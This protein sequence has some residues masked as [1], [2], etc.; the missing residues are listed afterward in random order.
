[1]RD[2]EQTITVVHVDD[3][4]EAAEAAATR[5]E[6]MDDRFTVRIA[7]SASE[8][9][10]LLTEHTVDCIVSAHELPDETGIDFLKAVRAERPDLPFVLYTGAGSEQVAAAAVSADATAYLRRDDDQFAALA[11]RI[12]E[13]VE[14]RRAARDAERADRRSTRPRER[15]VRDSVLRAQ[16]EAVIDGIL[17][18]DET[19]EIVTYNDRFVEMWD[20]ADEIVEK[21]DH[22]AALERAMDL[23]ADPEQFYEEIQRLYDNP[24]ETSRTEVELTDGRVFER[25]TAP[26][27]G[28]DGTHY[29]RLWTY[30]NITERK[31]RE[32]EL[33]RY[34]RI[35]Q[36][37]DDIAFVLDEDQIVE[38]VNET[39]ERQFDIPTDQVIGQ[40]IEALSLEYVAEHED[41][42]KFQAAID[43]VYDADPDADDSDR[44]ERIELAVEFPDGQYVFEYHLSPMIEDAE[45]TAVVVVMRDVTARRRRERE[46]RETKEQLDTVVRNAPIVLFALDDEGVF[47]LSEGKGLERLGLEPGEVVGMSVFD[48]YADQP[49][50][51]EAVETAL[52]GERTR[53][54]QTVD[55]LYFDTVYQPIIE[56]DGT[57]SGVIGVAMDITEQREYEQQLERQNQQLDE[58]AS[59]VSHDLR[60]PLNVAAGRLDL[61]REECDSD[62]LEHVERAHERMERLIDDLLTLAR[63]GEP[64]TEFVTV[65]LSE[66]VTSCW[67]T[68]E[69]ADAELRVEADRTIRADE[70]R[71]KQLFENLIRNAVEH[72]R[73]DVTVTVGAIQDGFY[74][75]DD[76]PGIPADEREEVFAA[77][78]S[79]TDEGTGFGLRIVEQIVDAHGW[80]ITV[81][82]GAEG[83]ARFE[84]TGITETVD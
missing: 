15:A 5:L 28:D 84:I 35:L 22:D 74:V 49:G 4:T 17:I 77:G 44:S 31:Q 13:A 8:G 25:Y 23:V 9:R 26:V 70:N 57:V 14:R 12:T 20:I 60:N 34:E 62:H 36:S 69:T 72:G 19:G 68:V 6:Q 2:G 30:R 33:E 51:I 29:G 48:L 59:V 83:G 43:R 82:D 46:L 73:D 38:Y 21:G 16:Q 75:E 66:V 39:L 76:G 27:T 37:I 11:E 80:D 52:E 1:M 78:Y 61:A 18:V 3:D 42:E 41:P 58:F 55:G 64:T 56:A 65:H 71:L 47:T 50:I 45:T 7:S 40:S 79:T 32:R 24:S 54:V 63:Q 10:Q 53:Y 67:E 81:T